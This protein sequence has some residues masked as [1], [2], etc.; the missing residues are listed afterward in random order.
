MRASLQ[1]R[2][3]DF[4]QGSPR[5]DADLPRLPPR[6]RCSNQEPARAIAAQLRGAE[7]GASVPGLIKDVFLLESQGPRARELRR[8]DLA[9][10]ALQH[11]PRPLRR[12]ARAGVA[13][14]PS[15]A[16]APGFP[17]DFPGGCRR[18]GRARADYLRLPHESPPPRQRPFRRAALFGGR[19]A[20]HHR[21]ARTPIGSGGS[22][23][24]RWWRFISAA[25]RPRSTGRPSSS[26]I[27]RR[28]GVDH[29][30]T[31][32]DR[33]GRS[34]PDTPRPRRCRSSAPPAARAAAAAADRRRARR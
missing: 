16:P 2:A 21:L 1:T 25:A 6:S 28:R 10:G 30:S 8:F 17:V 26:A 15:S 14:R 29:A 7:A 22:C 24:S 20:R 5:A 32:A 34:T 3:A 13:R 9:R 11:R 12:L 4:S 18:C 27:R 23:S 19:G 33:A 31:T